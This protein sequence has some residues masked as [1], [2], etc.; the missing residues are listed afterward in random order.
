MV[1]VQLNGW[2]R[3]LLTIALIKLIKAQAE[4][5]LSVAKN[6]VDRLLNGE[7]IVLEFAD[8]GLANAFLKDARSLG[9]IGESEI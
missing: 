1:R 7:I 8:L 6:H 3:G 9:A 5:S 4:L 2:K